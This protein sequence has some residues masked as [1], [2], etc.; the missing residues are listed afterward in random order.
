MEEV[1]RGVLVGAKVLF[2]K[3]PPMSDETR[4]SGV[5][6]QIISITIENR[7]SVHSALHIGF[8][9]PPLKEKEKVSK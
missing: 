2:G 8:E 3:L 6:V 4:A 7:T 9:L 1:S 5:A